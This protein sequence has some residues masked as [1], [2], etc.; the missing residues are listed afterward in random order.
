MS[1]IPLYVI[2]S[3]HRPHIFQAMVQKNKSKMCYF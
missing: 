3:L 1:I 2:H